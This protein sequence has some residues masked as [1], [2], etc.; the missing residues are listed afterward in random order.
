L[1]GSG[2]HQR[3]GLLAAF[4]GVHEPRLAIAPY[5]E[6]GTIP[7]EREEPKRF[8]RL[9]YRALAEKVIGE[10]RAAEFLGISVRRL[11]ERLDQGA[12]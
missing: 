10:A 8:E 4:S 1:K 12:A 5:E 7:P 11:E 2:R 3:S 9:C 6:P